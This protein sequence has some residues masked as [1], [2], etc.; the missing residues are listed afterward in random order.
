MSY[1]VYLQITDSQNNF[2]ASFL[3]DGEPPNCSKIFENLG[4]F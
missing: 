1:F 2:A 3:N 4:V